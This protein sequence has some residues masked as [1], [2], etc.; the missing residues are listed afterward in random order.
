VHVTATSARL[1]YHI[2]TTVRHLTAPVDLPLTATSPDDVML[3][4]PNPGPHDDVM[5]TSSTKRAK[6]GKKPYFCEFF[7]FS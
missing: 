6:K 3:T 5:L 4:S 7:H 1:T 2:A